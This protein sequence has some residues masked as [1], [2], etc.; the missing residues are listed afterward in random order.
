[1]SQIVDFVEDEDSRN[2]A[3]IQIIDGPSNVEII[4]LSESMDQ[5]ECKRAHVSSAEMIPSSPQRK[6]VSNDVEN[7]DLNKSIELSAPF[8]Q[9]ISISK[10]DDFSTTV[11][12]IIDSSLRNENNA[13]GNAKKLLDDLI[14]DEWSADLESS[15]KK[16]NKSQYNLR[17]I[18]EKWGV[19]SL[20]NR[21]PIAVDSE[22]KTQRIGKTNSDITDS[23]KSQIG[24]ADIL[25]DFPLSPVKHENPTEE[26][27]N[28]IAND[29]S[30]PDNSLKPAEKQNHGE[31]RKSMAKRVHNKGEDEQEHLPKGKK[32]TI[33]LSRTLINS[34]KLPDTVELN[35]SKFLDSSDSIT[36]DVLSTP[37]KGSNI[38]R[39]GSQPI[40]SNT[41]CFQEAKRSKTLTAEDPKCTK[42]TAREVSQLE[43]Y[44]AYGQYYTREDSKNKIRHLL[45][46]NKNAFKRV[47]QI[48]RD[49]I[50]ARSQMIIEFSPS[51]LQLFKKGDS[52][53]QQQL[54]PAV[55]QSSYND[56]MP[57]LRFL[58][59]CDSIYDFS[60][61]FYYPCDPKI[62]EENVL[63]LYYDAQEFFE[64][65]T[66]QKKEL[67]RKIRFFSKNG[68]HV[69][70]IL[71][72]LNKLK[73]AIFQLENEKYK[74][75]V[76]QRLSGTEEA[77]RPRSKKS[78]QVGKLGI[79]KFDLEQRLRFIDREW[80]V[81][82]H[83]V[84]S[85]MEFINSLPN[86]VSL[87]GKQRMDPA[88]RYMKYAHLNVKSAQDSTETLKKTFHQIGRMPEMKANNVVSLYPSFQSLLEDIEK[89]RLQS[90]N[91]G[92]YLMTEAVE[93]RLYKLFTSTD[94]NDTIE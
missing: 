2:D 32:R 87:I 67:Y 52:D 28:S 40:F 75:R 11:N 65:Y 20:K 14:S 27:H 68:K 12:S 22:Y 25:F 94:P 39:T 50:K 35:L 33:A 82:I 70:L 79:K 62:V 84:N 21:E 10:L 47:N 44:I 15:G 78:S 41:N 24:A 13:K 64:Q 6:S 19:Q 26:K 30:S 88:I 80:H 66:S 3:S 29:N 90:D 16:H 23:P 58:R 4:A 86:L 73:R 85:H 57:L 60:N 49:N 37:A 81:K 31:D 76:E 17:D 9:D 77:L 63:I 59:K 92:K 71:S 56:S 7:V 54:A 5:D 36:T 1:M 45:K 46:E 34:T 51:L 53:L 38:V 61:D 8:F 89:G 43:N 48:Y 69:I 93:K 83:T 72:D 42:N 91:E 74:A 18:A 55:V